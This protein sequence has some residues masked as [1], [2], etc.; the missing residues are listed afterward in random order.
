VA[1]HLHHPYTSTIIP[2]NP[3][4]NKQPK[5]PRPKKSKPTATTEKS[6]DEGTKVPGKGRG[7]SKENTQSDAKKDAPPHLPGTKKTI[8]DHFPIA[9]TSDSMDFTVSL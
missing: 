6:G 3:T 2:P 7:N 1:T 4:G 9:T 5:Q 8:T